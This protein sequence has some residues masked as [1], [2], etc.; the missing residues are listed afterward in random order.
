MA[1]KD[2]DGR[3]EY[4]LD[5]VTGELAEELGELDQLRAEVQSLKAQRAEREAEIGL[6]REQNRALE[7]A[8]AE[9]GQQHAEREAEFG[10]QRSAY[11]TD[12]GLLR[13]QNRALAGKV[14]QP[15]RPS[16]VDLQPQP[17]KR[18]GNAV[19]AAAHQ[20]ASLSYPTPTHPPLP[21]IS[22]PSSSHP[23]DEPDEKVGALIIDV[24]TGELKLMAALHFARVEMIEL[25]EV[26]IANIAP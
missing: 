26:N 2:S 24:G 12:I 7:L 17:D 1:R 4:R 9:F 16:S 23:Q 6:L 21:L 22:D 5:R 20:S 25:V 19:Q 13:E 8:A 15:A 18:G 14:E 3:Q 11:E 10:Q